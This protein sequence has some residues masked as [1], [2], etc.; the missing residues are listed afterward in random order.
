MRFK[1][2][3]KNI[4]FNDLETDRIPMPFILLSGSE[5]KQI[6][7]DKMWE[8]QKDNIFY[9]DGANPGMIIFK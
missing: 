5:S 9:K 2:I 6:V 4:V 8:I 1:M 3:D 7:M